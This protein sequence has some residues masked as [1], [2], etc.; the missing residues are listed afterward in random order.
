MRQEVEQPFMKLTLH[1]HCMQL[2]RQDGM[3]D[4]IEGSA[5]VQCEKIAWQLS[6]QVLTDN[7]VAL[8][9]ISRSGSIG[10]ETMLLSAYEIVV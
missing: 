8:K 6:I 7:V 3:R 1:T 2:V 10:G 5:E 4:L 9:K